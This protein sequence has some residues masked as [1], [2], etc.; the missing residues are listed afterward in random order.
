MGV[1]HPLPATPPS[2]RLGTLLKLAWPIIVSR[3]SQVVVG[4]ADALMVAGLGEAALAATTTG[5]MNSFTLLILPM[6]VVFI[7]SSFSS[8]YFG[9]GDL[10]GARRY[11]FYGLIV[12]G[13]TSV[14][15]AAVIPSAGWVLGKLDYA[16]DVRELMT[17]YLAIRLWSAGAVVGMEALGA[18]YG[19]LG[20]TRVQMVA[21]LAA[22]ALNVWGNYLLIAGRWGFPA[23]GVRGAAWASALASTAA[24][25]GLLGYFLWDSRA[26]VERLELSMRE[27][28]RMLRFGIPAGF[29]WFFEFMAFIFFVNTVVAGLGTTS[30]AAMMAVL[31]INSAS[32]MPAFA[33][34][35]AGA[36][37]VGQLIGAGMKDEVP[38]AVRLTFL[39]SGGW[40]G[41]VGL[42]Y[43][44]APETLFAPFAKGPSGS[45]QL[46]AVGVRLLMLSAAWQ[47]FDATAICLGEAL[48]AAGDTAFSLWARLVVGWALFVPGSWLTARY[49]DGGEV[50]AMLWVVGYLGVLALVLFVRFRAG[51]WRRIELVE[52]PT[53]A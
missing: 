36:I 22:M 48:R 42:V 46:L 17:A 10:A 12:A 38:K 16:P 4:L 40:M 24:F 5:A 19:G 32:F 53:L 43:F 9:R 47:L 3:S 27:L 26:L 49:L 2:L 1:T 37:I 25:A 15:G 14:L 34:S 50:A 45:G 33:I 30:L 18:Y 31:Q 7:V 41:V 11:A 39:T 6:G 29:N 35:S 21:A 28:G 51:A 44:L 8:Q 20:R 13:L 52:E 23:L